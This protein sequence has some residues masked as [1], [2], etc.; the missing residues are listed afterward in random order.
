[1]LRIYQSLQ[2]EVIS[3]IKNYVAHTILED[4]SLLRISP[5]EATKHLISTPEFEFFLKTH[6][7]EWVE[8]FVL[9]EL[10]TEQFITLRRCMRSKKAGVLNQMVMGDCY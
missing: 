9:A 7:R 1:V 3:H 2:I 4:T 6:I 5:S 10:D 8:R